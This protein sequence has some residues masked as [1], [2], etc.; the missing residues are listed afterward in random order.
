MSEFLKGHDQHPLTES[1]PHL[2]DLT[3]RVGEQTEKL[4]L[5]NQNGSPE[6]T[7]GLLKD[8]VAELA[9]QIEESMITG[10]ATPIA[11]EIGDVLYLTLKLCHSLG[12][13]PADAVQ[14]KIL[15]ND[16][17]YSTDLNSNGNYEDSRQ[18]SK[19]LWAAMGGD[20]AFSHAYLDW[21]GQILD[22]REE[23][24]A[25]PEQVIYQSDP[26][27]TIHQGNDYY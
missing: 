20:V 6:H 12:I 23:K 14:I 7:V 21:M 19:S 17:K 4:D 16:L 10:E 3:R 22:E 27:D 1:N 15:R 13:N 18:K 5:W 8:E 25:Q 26:W 11:M 2:N 9:E 24:E